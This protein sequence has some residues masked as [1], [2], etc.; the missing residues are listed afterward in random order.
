MSS[1]LSFFISIVFG[2]YMNVVHVLPWMEDN[3]VENGSLMWIFILFAASAGW[4]IITDSVLNFLVY[5]IS[6]GKS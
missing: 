5:L 1:F 6:G 3:N 4:V 2:V